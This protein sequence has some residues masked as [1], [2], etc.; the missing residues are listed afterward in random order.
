M[1]DTLVAVEQRNT[2][3]ATVVEKVYQIREKKER[4]SE[5]RFEYRYILFRSS[6]Y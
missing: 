3:P 1:T 6:A 4:G 2:V 5:K